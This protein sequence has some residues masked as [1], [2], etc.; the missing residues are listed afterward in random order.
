MKKN[1]TYEKL[2]D[3]AKAVLAGKFIALK[4]L[5]YK[6]KKVSNNLSFY[7]KKLENR[8]KYTQIKQKK[9]MKVTS[10]INKNQD[11]NTIEKNH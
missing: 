5:C 3:V 1:A 8:V 11:R 4:C 6:E 9:I 2:W 7:L 10:E